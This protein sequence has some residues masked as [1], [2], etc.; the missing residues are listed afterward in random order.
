MRARMPHLANIVN[1]ELGGYS[2]QDQALDELPASN[3]SLGDNVKLPAYAGKLSDADPS[4]G[5]SLKLLDWQKFRPV[6]HVP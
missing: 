3:C 5:R 6:P 2:K 1:E 4:V